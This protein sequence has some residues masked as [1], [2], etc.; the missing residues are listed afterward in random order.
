[1]PNHLIGRMRLSE[2]RHVFG[3]NPTSATGINMSPKEAFEIYANKRPV[4]YE[5]PQK[6]AAQ[7]LE[8]FWPVFNEYERF[9]LLLEA[10][11]ADLGEGRAAF[12]EV[13]NE[14]RKK[15]WP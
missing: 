7:A 12:D 6:K 15:Y 14:L 3:S 11:H 8:V 10:N 1:M 4:H 5:G 9:K 2:G 13:C